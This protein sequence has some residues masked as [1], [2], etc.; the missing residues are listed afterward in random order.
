[1]VNILKDTKI[2]G[3]IGELLVQLRLLEYDIQAAPPIKDSGNDLI[4][5]K[6]EIFRAVQVKT[7]R[8]DKF[9]LGNLPKFHIL[10]LVHLISENTTI[11][12]DQSKIYLLLKN[13]VN[14]KTYRVED[15]IG[16]EI[17]TDRVNML[18]R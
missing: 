11:L 7:S 14:K 18:F 5:I 1:M 16:K 17:S 15:L 4:A 8:I 13:E 12:L 10:A 3:T 9:I 2:T 6:G